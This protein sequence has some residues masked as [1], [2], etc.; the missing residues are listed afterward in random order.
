MTYN[1]SMIKTTN[2]QKVTFYLLKSQ[3]NT[4]TTL[5]ET[6]GDSLSKI[7]RTAIAE[8]IKRHKIK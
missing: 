7:Y 1:I 4:I 2:K 8:Y 5:S 6:T 3:Y